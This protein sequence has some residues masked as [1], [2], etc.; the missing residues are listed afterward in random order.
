MLERIRESFLVAASSDAPTPEAASQALWNSYKDTPFPKDDLAAAREELLE[1]RSK[2]LVEDSL[3]SLLLEMCQEAH[4]TK[5]NMLLPKSKRLLDIALWLASNKLLEP[6]LPC[7][8]VEDLVEVCATPEELEEVFD[9]IDRE[10]AVLK[11]PHIFQRG[12]L[13]LLRSFNKVL[14]Q[15]PGGSNAD[16]AGRIL[17]C[18]AYLW[19]LIERSAVNHVGQY[20]PCQEINMTVKEEGAVMYDSRGIPVNGEF[21][22]KFWTLLKDF[23][24][25]AAPS[26]KLPSICRDLKSVI[27]FIKNQPL[28]YNT[29][30]GGLGVGGHHS[31]QYTTEPGLF[32]LQLQDAGFR[33]HFLLECL[34]YLHRLDCPGKLNDP[35]PSSEVL[36]EVKSVQNEIVNC[37]RRTGVEGSSLCDSMIQ[38]FKRE[39]QWVKW[40]SGGC[41]DWTLSTPETEFLD[42]HKKNGE[43]KAETLNWTSRK[44]GRKIKRYCQAQIED[45]YLIGKGG[46]FVPSVEGVSEGYQYPNVKEFVKPLL[47]GDL[48]PTLNAADKATY[49]W[50]VYRLMASENHFSMDTSAP[51]D[52]RKF[53]TQG[54]PESVPKPEP[55]TNGNENSGANATSSSRTPQSSRGTKRKDRSSGGGGK[56]A[57]EQQ[58]AAP[59]EENGSPSRKQ[60]TDDGKSTKKG[61]SVSKSNGEGRATPDVVIIKKEENS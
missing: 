40:K 29:T 60:K 50:R 14:K 61:E 13:I 47:E 30:R 52:I 23:K 1:I 5:Q 19:P 51:L 26:T 27:G 32:R 6:G 18:M 21:Y 11:Q 8:L 42:M 54:F 10:K 25:S 37:L 28:K 39:D 35:S 20:N 38:Q 3:R 49:C 59:A 36:Q 16:L 48:P 43:V 2:Q 53:V 7:T 31:L 56:D 44:R 15:I 57:A 45:Q 9:W 24:D 34:I 17:L 4:K 22:A 46:E 58:Q 41:K 12:K 33:C 55:P